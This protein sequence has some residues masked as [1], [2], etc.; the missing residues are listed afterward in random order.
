MPQTAN[1]PAESAAVADFRRDI[2]YE[3]RLIVLY[4][5]LGWRSHIH[6]AGSDHAKIGRLRRALLRHSR[7]ARARQSLDIRVSTFSDHVVITQEVGSKNE[8]LMQQLGI[9]QFGS[10]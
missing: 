2:A 1:E 4:D 10:A 3:Q 8:P 9:F 7:I 5:F 6:H